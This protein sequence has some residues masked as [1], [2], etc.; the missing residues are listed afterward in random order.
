MHL[1]VLLSS[2]YYQLLS[3]AKSFLHKSR[4][5]GQAIKES[6]HRNGAVSVWKETEL[7]INAPTAS[8]ICSCHRFTN[9]R[10]CVEHSSLPFTDLK[11]RL[12]PLPLGRYFWQGTR[13]ATE[14]SN[15]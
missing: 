1:A 9:C 11:V 7:S 5:V 12:V 10:N 3:L 13:H 14:G 6:P 2:Y 4:N 15:S 8:H